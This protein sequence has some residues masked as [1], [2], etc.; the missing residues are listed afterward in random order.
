MEIIKINIFQEFEKL[1]EIKENEFI[2]NLEDCP[3]HQRTRIVDIFGGLTFLN[4]SM[5]KLNNHEFEIKIVK[6]NA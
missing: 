6:E 4:G 3:F 2:I 1:I 5:K